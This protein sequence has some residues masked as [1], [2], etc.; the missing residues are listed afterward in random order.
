MGPQIAYC[1]QPPVVHLEKAQLMSMGDA[2][3]EQ[4][5]PALRMASFSRAR[6]GRKEGNL[7]LRPCE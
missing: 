5:K 3:R 1:H 2:G 4:D 6:K 7:K